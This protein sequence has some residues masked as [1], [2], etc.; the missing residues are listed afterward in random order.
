MGKLEC[1]RC[2]HEISD[3]GDDLPHRAFVVSDADRTAQRDATAAALT[4]LAA[5]GADRGA[6]EAWFRRHFP[7]AMP[8]QV[9]TDD[10]VFHYL[11][12]HQPLV[13][14]V[15]YEC[16]SC[17]ALHLQAAPGENRYLAFAP[18]DDARG[19]LAPARGGG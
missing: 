8:A 19:V 4:E 15:M 3:G 1:G 5:A 10:L 11:A 2:G 9:T 14:R 17:G 13:E 16:T 12:R 6:R 18:M 7:H